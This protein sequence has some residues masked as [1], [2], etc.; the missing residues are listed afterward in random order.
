MGKREII[1]N[2]LAK[3]GKMKRVRI[4]IVLLVLLIAGLYFYFSSF[5]ST[6][7]A[8][9]EGHIAFISAQAAGEVTDVKVDD[10]QAVD[11]GDELL[12][13]DPRQYKYNLD[14]ANANVQSAQAELK[15][16]EEDQQ[17]YKLLLEHKDI[18][19]QEYDRANLKVQTVQAQ[20]ARAKALQEQAEL[21]LEHTQVKTAISGYISAKTVEK[22]QYVQ[23][24]Q[25]LLSV[26][27]K[28]VW[29]VANFKETQMANIVPGAPAT[30]TVDAYPGLRIKGH[31]DSIQSGTGAVFS[32]LPAQNASGNFIKVV[33]RVPV[34]IVFDDTNTNLPFLYPGLSVRVYVA[35]RGK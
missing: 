12:Q 20:L 24:G 23:V 11:A 35:T 21:N 29:V 8:F 18:S 4:T 30:I 31:V 34:K 25:P 9:L 15:Q 5:Q 16:A 28:R 27:S 33:Q 22:G 2:Q 19:Q 26:V 32:L 6:D 3:Y 17:R 13:I 14:I 7:D 10:N 1:F